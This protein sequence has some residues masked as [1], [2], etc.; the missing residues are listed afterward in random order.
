MSVSE[1][2]EGVPQRLPPRRSKSAVLYARFFGNR[3]NTVLT[4][5]SAAIAWLIGAT[6][7]EW[8]ILDAVW[9]GSPEDCRVEGTGACWAAV[10]E[11]S[12]L[13]IFGIFPQ[14][15]L[16]R[17]ALVVAGFSLLIT[18]TALPRLYGRRLILAWLLFAVLS[19]M[20]LHGGLFGW[21][22]VPTRFWSG[23]PLTIVLAVFA[24]LLSLPLSILLALGRADG[25][26][27]IRWLCT[28][29]IEAVRGVPL[30]MLLFMGFLILPL[31]FSAAFT[32]DVLIR[33]QLA[34]ILFYSVI[35]A[36]VIRG[37]LQSVSEGQTDAASSLG[38]N[39]WQRN[40]FVVLPQA[41]KAVGPGLV[42][43]AIMATKDTSLVT[44]IGLID[45]FG[46]A[47][48]TT[49][50]LDWGQVNLEIYIFISIF[51]L[52]ICLSLARLGDVLSKQA[53]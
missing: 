19:P 24:I 5:L 4:L 50:D 31:F 1:A 53:G 13:I 12:R 34:I 11:K 46:A 20:I 37:G 43:N 25:P 47:R 32:P 33:A 35:N 10:I 39:Y 42:N 2:Q 40:L 21:V 27:V 9:S 28:G 45:L 14:E 48:T 22:S 41:L 49:Q 26:P 52:L 17:A 8:G 18:A 51:Y 36:E 3:Y 15:A 6:I 30:L 23:L 38:L 7:L 16:W 29:L 44:I